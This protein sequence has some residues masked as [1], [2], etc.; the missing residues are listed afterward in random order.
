MLPSNKSTS[1]RHLTDTL[2]VSS[3]NMPP[4]TVFI[5]NRKRPK[6]L[7]FQSPARLWKT[8]HAYYTF[9]R[10]LLH[11][12]S[13]TTTLSVADYYTFSHQNPQNLAPLLAFPVRKLLKPP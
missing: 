2:P 3:S 12:Q 8:R 9:S 7:H 4:S 1:K 5:S 6:I 11:F 13:Q 10:R